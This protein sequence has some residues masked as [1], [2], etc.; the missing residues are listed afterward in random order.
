MRSRAVP[1]LLALIASGVL[2][3]A[4]IVPAAFFS[5]ASADEGTCTATSETPDITLLKKDEPVSA[6]NAVVAWEMLKLQ[7]TLELNDG[8]CAGQT[9][10]I[11]TPEKLRFDSGTT[12]NLDTEDGQTAATM[13]YVAD[14]DGS[15]GRLVITLTDYVESHH[16]ISLNGW[17]DTRLTSAITPSTTELLTFS[18]NGSEKILEVPVGECVGNCTE[19]PNYLAKFGS[20]PAPNAQGVSTGNVTLQTP[21]ITQEMAA[22]ADSVTLGWTDELTSPNQAFTCEASAYSYTGRNVWGDPTGGTPTQV[23]V[24]S[25]E[26]NS[27][28]GTVVI[29]VGQFA[30][31]ILPMNFTGAGPWTDRATLII[32]SRDIESE[33]KVILR[34]GGGSAT[35]RVPTP[36][37][38]KESPAPSQTPTPAQPTPSESATP[39]ESPSAAAPSE[40][41][42]PSQPS[43]ASESP[44]AVAKA[45]TPAAKSSATRPPAL[46]RTGSNGLA[47]VLGAGAL[48]ILGG[49]AV[50]RARARK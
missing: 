37:T 15:K 11:S 38:P 23:T 21:T 6:D 1:R 7:F 16:D 40:S 18:T 24:T 28:S 14:E 10:E 42:A 26:D 32:G 8:H 5:P 49:A 20:A 17:V 48:L 36:S 33:A 35:G 27:I 25:C 34:D 3:L 31:I 30:R 12:W 19:M 41:A 39:S 13:T 43:Q 22:G 46:A 2:A 9:Y 29:P 47:L 44:S 45:T 50:Y 4:L